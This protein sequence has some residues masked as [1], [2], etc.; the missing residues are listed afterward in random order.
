MECSEN[1]ISPLVVKVCVKN[2]NLTLSKFLNFFRLQFT[3]YCNE[4]ILLEDN[5]STF[6]F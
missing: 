5:E 6:Q 3:H 4:G 1:D 2:A